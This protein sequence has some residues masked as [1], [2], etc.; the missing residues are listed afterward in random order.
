MSND[1][2]KEPKEVKEYKERL[3]TAQER[4]YRSLQGADPRYAD[5]ILD[6]LTLLRELRLI[7]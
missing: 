4:L 6:V 5:A 2:K 3:K 1:I 7:P